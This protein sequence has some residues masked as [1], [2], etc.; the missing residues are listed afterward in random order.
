MY[1]VFKAFILQQFH[2]QSDS[3]MKFTTFLTCSYSFFSQLSIYS[4]FQSIFHLNSREL[5]REL[6]NLFFAWVEVR[7][8]I[9]LVQKYY[10]SWNARAFTNS[11]AFVCFRPKSNRNIFLARPV[12]HIF[13][14]HR[15]IF[16]FVCS[17][18]HI[19]QWDTQFAE[20]CHE[21]LGVRQL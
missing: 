7:F 20:E 21:N 6:G 8:D 5:S 4:N 13:V 2:F 10:N 17:V 19:P 3:T 14:K 9:V 18:I 1:I 11:C 12:G 16:L 15:Y